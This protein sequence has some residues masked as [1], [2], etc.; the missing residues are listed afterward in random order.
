LAALAASA[1]GLAADQTFDLR[2]TAG[3][4]GSNNPLLSTQKSVAAMLLEMSVEPTL[5][6]KTPTSTLEIDGR[7]SRRQYSREYSA[8]TYGGA[9]ASILKRTSE[10]FEFN[11]SAYYSRDVVV[12][13]FESVAAAV[14]P[15]SISTNKGLTAGAAIQLSEGSNLSPRLSIRRHSYG[16]SFTLQDYTTLSGGT[17][18]SRPLNEYTSIGASVDTAV[19]QYEGPGRSAV[20][21][22]LGTAVHNFDERTNLEVGLGVERSTISGF[23][24]ANSNGRILPSGKV[25]LCRLGLDL[26]VCLTGSA[27]SDATGIGALQRQL[28]TGFTVGY[29]PDPKTNIL[30]RG[31]Y[32]RAS[33]TKGNQQPTLKFLAF[34]AT[35]DRKL[36][37]HFSVAAFA[38]YRH[39]AG[40]GRAS[41]TTIGTELRFNLGHY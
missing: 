38:D 32:Q 15:N 13:D 36:N 24:A 7:I 12:D 31:D 4:S 9:T 11:G 14:D 40:F 33:S 28:S 17:S 19:Q 27:R 1:A 25:N 10:R 23:G 2:A 29:Q 22:V 39:R 8:A 5:T 26:K 21:S 18:Y 3:L 30:L 35:A 20:L 41:S 6:R 34:R 37:G 16:N